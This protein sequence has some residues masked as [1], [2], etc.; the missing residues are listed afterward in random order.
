MSPV[1]TFEKI[2]SF[3]FNFVTILVVIGPDGIRC[4]AT[5][6]DPARLTTGIE[7]V[8][9]GGGVAVKDDAVTGVQNGR[10]VQR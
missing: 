8:M 4:E 1:D 10:Y 5:Y 7:M 6:L 2:I 9:V 3:I